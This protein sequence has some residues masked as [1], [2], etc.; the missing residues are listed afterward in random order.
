VRIFENENTI[1]FLDN[2]AFVDKSQLDNK[3]IR[4]VFVNSEAELTLMNAEATEF[5][6]YIEATNKHD[7]RMAIQDCYDFAYR[8]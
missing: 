1:I 3:E 7:A 5:L 6:S 2:I 4:I 8:R